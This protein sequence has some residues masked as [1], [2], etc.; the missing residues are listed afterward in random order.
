VEKMGGSIRVES[1]PG[2]GSTFI[3]T[4]A[5]RKAKLSIEDIEPLYGDQNKGAVPKTKRNILII[6]SDESNIVLLNVILSGKYSISRISGSENMTDAAERYKPELLI[7]DLNMQ[8][9]AIGDFLP[10]LNDLSHTLPLF[11]IQPASRSGVVKEL[12]GIPVAER[13]VKPINIKWLLDLLDKY[14]GDDKE[15]REK[16]SGS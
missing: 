12:K 6:G 3:F 9:Q 13:I 1:E 14:L 4:I 8:K 11:T 5:Y 16:V 10:L 2:K 15:K 7:F